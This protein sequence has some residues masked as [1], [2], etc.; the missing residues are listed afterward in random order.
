MVCGQGTITPAPAVSAAPPPAF[1][2]VIYG[3]FLN[4]DM[5]LLVRC[6]GAW[7]SISHRAVAAWVAE[8]SYSDYQVSDGQLMSASSGSR[9]RLKLVVLASFG[10]IIIL[11][12]MS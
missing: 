8:V 4:L 10:L 12:R 3:Q 2:R 7:D 6:D 11:S 9:R 5:D 1:Q